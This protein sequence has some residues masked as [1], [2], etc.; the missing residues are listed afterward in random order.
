M[1]ALAGRQLAQRLRAFRR[2][3]RGI[4]TPPAAVVIVLALA[5]TFNVTDALQRPVPDYTA[6]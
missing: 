5:L 2:H 6:A 1:F 3:Q 4:R